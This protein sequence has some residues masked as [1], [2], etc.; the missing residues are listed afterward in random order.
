M[1]SGEADLTRLYGTALAMN[2]YVRGGPIEVPPRLPRTLAFA[3][4]IDRVVRRNAVREQHAQG[5]DHAPA[6]RFGASDGR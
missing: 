2:G 5:A 3:S 1:V 4:R 6:A